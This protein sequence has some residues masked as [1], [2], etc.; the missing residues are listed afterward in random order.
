MFG[1][2][3][4]Y[5]EFGIDIQELLR[6]CLLPQDRSDHSQLFYGHIFDDGKNVRVVESTWKCEDDMENVEEFAMKLAAVLDPQGKA[7]IAVVPDE[8]YQAYLRE[9]ALEA[10]LD[11]QLYGDDG[12]DVRAAVDPSLVDQSKQ[13]ESK[14]DS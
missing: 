12:D 6:Y 14:D 13:D 7:Q 2:Q 10:E 9:L 3:R 4:P 5:G 1:L 11:T 8:D